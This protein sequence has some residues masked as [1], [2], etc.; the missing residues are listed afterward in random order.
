M[1]KI[2]LLGLGFLLSASLTAQTVTVTLP[3]G[4]TDITGTTITL[5]GGETIYETYDVN[6]VSSGALDLRI[7][8]VKMSEITGS[9]DYVCWGLDELTGTCYPS[10]VVAPN[11]P[12][13][14][15]DVA[16]VADGSAAWLSIYYDAN[17]N[18]G[19][20]EYRYYIVNASDVRVDSFD[21]RYASTVSIEEETIE[22][23]L[24]PNPANDIVNVSLNGNDNNMNVD[25][26]NVLGEAVLTQNLVNGVNTLNTSDLVGGVYFYSIRRGDKVIET[27]KLVIKR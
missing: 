21:V 15:P 20:S 12:W 24:Y 25:I 14:S 1:K 16:A 10:S 17:G 2:Y 27:K 7:E 9:T 13:V 5:D 8:R 23:S 22:V 19:T 18:V 6:N 4:S 3:G 26:Y 11:N